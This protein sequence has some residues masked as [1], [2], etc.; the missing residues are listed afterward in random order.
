MDN[1]SSN[2]RLFFTM[3]PDDSTRIYSLLADLVL[4][5]L[6]NADVQSRPLSP[7]LFEKREERRMSS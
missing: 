4:L 1:T 6:S 3:L 2:R 5:P 7:L